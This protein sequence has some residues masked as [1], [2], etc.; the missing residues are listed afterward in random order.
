MY[1]F[2]FAIDG[3]PEAARAPFSEIKKILRKIAIE[4]SRQK[5]GV[6]PKKCCLLHK[7]FDVVFSVT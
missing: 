6:Q 7:F 2:I 3:K 5:K 4:R 1:L